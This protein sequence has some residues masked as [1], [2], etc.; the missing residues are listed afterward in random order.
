M[1]ECTDRSRPGAGTASTSPAGAPGLYSGLNTRRDGRGAGSAGSPDDRAAGPG[2][3]SSD[4]VD[5]Y[6]ASPITALSQPPH[7]HGVSHLS[8]AKRG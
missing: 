5:T 4:G 8:L 7:S 1:A 3:L 2:C 6:T